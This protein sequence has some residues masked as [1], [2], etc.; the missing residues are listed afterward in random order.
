LVPDSGFTATVLAGAQV[1]FIGRPQ[2]LFKGDRLIIPSTIGP[3]FDVVQFTIANIPQSLAEGSIPA[4]IFSEV[5]TYTEMN[6]DQAYPGVLITL[7]ALN[8]SA[9]TQIFQ[10]SLIGDAVG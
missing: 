6:F 9:V 1:R 10:A 8:K 5:S 7:T 2:K 3:F 4:D